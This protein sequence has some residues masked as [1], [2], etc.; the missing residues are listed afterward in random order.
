[1]RRAIFLFVSM[2]VA[3]CSFA[4]TTDSKTIALHARHANDGALR[5]IQPVNAILDGN[6][7]RIDFFNSFEN[8]KISITDMS[9]NVVN[10][11]ICRYPDVIQFEI[12]Q[13]EDSYIL[14]ITF[15]NVKLSGTFIID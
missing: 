3:I 15:S 6:I 7:V 13:K 10:T 9:G 4:K 8:V 5:S 14:E 12:E 1:M 11:A 2:I